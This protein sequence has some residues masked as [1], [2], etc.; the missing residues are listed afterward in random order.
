LPIEIKLRICYYMHNDYA[1]EHDEALRGV[2]RSWFYAVDKFTLENLDLMSCRKILEANRS[3]S[4]FRKIL[5]KLVGNGDP[6][7]KPHKELKD[8]SRHLVKSMHL[9]VFTKYYGEILRLSYPKLE[10]LMALICPENALEFEKFIKKNPKIQRLGFMGVCGMDIFTTLG[11]ERTM[12]FFSPVSQNLTELGLRCLNLRFKNMT[13]ILSSFPNLRKLWLERLELQ[14]TSDLFIPKDR[15]NDVLKSKLEFK[16][17]PNLVSIFLVWLCVKDKDALP[18]QDGSVVFNTKLM[19]CLEDMAFGKDHNQTGIPEDII[20]YEER[21][22]SGVTLNTITRLSLY[23]P[24]RPELADAIASGCPNL[25]KLGLA[26]FYNTDE[27]PQTQAFFWNLSKQCMPNLQGFCIQSKFYHLDPDTMFFLGDF[28]SCDQLSQPTIS[29]AF[30]PNVIKLP[31][32]DITT[33]PKKGMVVFNWNSRIKVLNFGFPM[34]AFPTDLL[35]LAQFKSLEYLALHLATLHGIDEVRRTLKE[36]EAIFA[37][38]EENGYVSGSLTGSSTTE[39]MVGSKHEETQHFSKL[40]TLELECCE[41][42]YSQIEVEILLGIFPALNYVSFTGDSHT[43]MDS[44]KKKYPFTIF[45][46]QGRGT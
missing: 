6:G 36:E 2:S 4:I 24:L 28:V 15:A 43:F 32:L 34:V 46:H 17:F 38:D 19:P 40:H 11:F 31:S 29:G 30:K 20:L 25:E 39:N 23:Q 21:I 7:I 26:F 14:E 45:T 1:P 5:M 22:F 13:T 35:V 10:E 3:R 8:Y 44:I 33:G 37:Y 12:E 9:N 16:Q 18:P 42:N 41:Q 27:M